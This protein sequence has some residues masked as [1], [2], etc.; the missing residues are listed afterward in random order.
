MQPQ[1]QTANAGGSV[2]FSASASGTSPISYQWKFDTT[3]ISG[4]TN[5]SLTLLNL[6]TNAAGTYQVIA[7]SPYGS[8]ASSNATLAVLVTAVEAGSVSAAGGASVAVPVELIAT[9]SE[10]TWVSAS[11]LIRRF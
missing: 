4:A 2:T 3:N 7:T 11:I 9:G 8:A 10:N 6:K 5:S 1:S